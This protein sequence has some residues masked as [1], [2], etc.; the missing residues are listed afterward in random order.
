[1][2]MKKAIQL[3]RL[4]LGIVL[5]IPVLVICVLFSIVLGAP[6]RLL[7]QKRAA[8]SIAQCFLAIAVRW[9]MICLGSKVT[10]LGKENLPKKGE[11]YC[12]IPNHLSMIDIPAVFMTGRWPGIVSKAEVWKIPILHALLVLL[13]CIKLNRTSPKDAIKAIHDGVENI[14]SGIPMLIFPEGTRSKTGVIGEFKAGSFKMATRS[15]SKIVPVVLKNTRECFE[16]AYYPGIVP[17]YVQILPSID[18]DGMEAEEL[19]EL[20]KRVENA[21]KEAYDKLPDFPKRK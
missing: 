9:I 5:I 7:R 11:K 10:V 1:M 19:K 17:V 21:I 8:S 12:M 2:I 14:N 4:I 20:P 15:K 18:T 13:N 16:S 3:F 6:L